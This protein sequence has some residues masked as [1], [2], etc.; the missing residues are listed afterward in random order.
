MRSDKEHLCPE[1]TKG[2]L[3]EHKKPCNIVRERIKTT[4]E[5]FIGEL[6]KIPTIIFDENE[7]MNLP[8]ECLYG[9]IDRRCGSEI[10]LYCT[11][12]KKYFKLKISA[13]FFKMGQNERRNI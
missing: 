10:T 5:W 4:R 8:T 12:H 7:I 1:C 3:K 9:N 11:V 2:Y 6:K 13:F